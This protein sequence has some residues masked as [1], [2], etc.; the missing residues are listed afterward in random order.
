MSSKPLKIIH[1][2]PCNARL[3]AVF[4]PGACAV[5]NR[6][7]ENSLSPS[8]QLIDRGEYRAL[9]DEIDRAKGRMRADLQPRI[10]AAQA[11][12][13]P[14]QY[15][16]APGEALGRPGLA[17]P[18]AARDFCHGLPWTAGGCRGLAGCRRRKCR[19]RSCVP[20]ETRSPPGDNSR[21][22]CPQC[23][24]TPSLSGRLRWAALTSTTVP[25]PGIRLAR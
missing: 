6:E 10:P 3:A 8:A 14:W 17:G 7:S 12:G 11:P 13:S 23:T 22:R 4:G 24:S 18:G 19:Q 21:S 16:T 5:G 1:N 20:M 9:F 15:L 2:S 25:E